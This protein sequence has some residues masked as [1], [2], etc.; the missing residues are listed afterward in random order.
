MILTMIKEYDARGPCHLLDEV[1]ALRIIFR[2]DIVVILERLV[3]RRMLVVLESGG[4]ERDRVL[5]APHVLDNDVFLLVAKVL[6]L[7]GDGVSVDTLIRAHAVFGWQEVRE[8][9]GGRCRSRGHCFLY[10]AIVRV[11]EKLVNA[12]L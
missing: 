7:A 3:L 6:A 9:S 1:C 2:T 11:N 10:C 12:L 5:F 8:F 4:I